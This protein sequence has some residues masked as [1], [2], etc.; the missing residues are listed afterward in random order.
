MINI[1]SHVHLGKDDRLG[2]ELTLEEL[3]HVIQVHN[4]DYAVVFP[5]P[6]DSSNPTYVRRNK[7]IIEAAMQFSNLIP[8][9]MINP[10]S[11]DSIKAIRNLVENS[12]GVKAFKF[13]PPAQNYAPQMIIGSEIWNLAISYKLPLIFHTS[14]IYEETAGILDV[15]EKYPYPVIAAHAFRLHK[16]LLT[17]ASTIPNLYVDISPMNTLISL[18]DSLAVSKQI[19]PLELQNASL[20]P[21]FVTRYL[22]NL[23]DSRLIWGSDLPWSANL[24]N[25]EGEWNF[26]PKLDFGIVEKMMRNAESIFLA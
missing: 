15:A 18:V 22:F 9:F 19:M 7:E 14:K 21:E 26:L 2:Y 12:E 11:S 3:E 1:D 13:Y 4:I 17:K 24:S 25:A 20:T 23:M 6:W 5:C 8:A 10:L 16:D